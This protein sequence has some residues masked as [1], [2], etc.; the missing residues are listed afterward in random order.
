MIEFV[1]FFEVYGEG[2]RPV[3]EFVRVTEG[4]GD[5][6]LPGFRYDFDVGMFEVSRLRV[7][8]DPEV[9]IVVVIEKLIES[10]RGPRVFR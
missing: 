6:P 7:E 4:L 8:S 10:C 3:V 1:G 9:V 5:T 2:D